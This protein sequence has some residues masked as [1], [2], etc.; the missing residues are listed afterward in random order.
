M[1]YYSETKWCPKCKTYVRYMMSVDGSYCAECGGPVRL[2]N[3]E[4]LDRFTQ[5]MEKRR[6]KAS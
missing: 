4:D 2:F 6:W 3:K 1:D 5:D